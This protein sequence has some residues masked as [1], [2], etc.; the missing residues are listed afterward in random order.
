VTAQPAT[1]LVCDDDERLRELMRVTLGPAYTYVEAGDAEQ[2]LH[3][4][5]SA[6][7]DVAL[8]DVMMPGRS[9]IDLLREM[10][11]D[12]DLRAIPVVVVSAWSRESDR[13]SAAEAGADAFIGKPF[14]LDDLRGTVTDLLERR[15]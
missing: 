6:H 9:G 10:R 8:L 4:L 3:L 2:A 7:P 5:R 12:P 11:G 1:I 14:E 13:D 15:R